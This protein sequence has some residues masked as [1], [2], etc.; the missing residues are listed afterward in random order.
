MAIDS[1]HAPMEV[2]SRARAWFMTMAFVA[3]RKPAW[4]DFQTAIFASD[5][6]ME[7]VLQTSNG[8]SPPVTH[9]VTAWAATAN[10][11][12][13]Q[14]RIS[15]KPLVQFVTN[16][17]AWVHRWSWAAPAGSSGHPRA[18]MDLPPAVAADV[19]HLRAQAR[20]W[21]SMAARQRADTNRANKGQGRD[22]NG[23]KGKGKDHSKQGVGKGKDRAWQRDN[24][25]RDDRRD[26]SRRR[27]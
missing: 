15:G 8:I 25:D 2:Y 13:E 9:F 5:K 18:L 7:L 11:F 12:S 24:D 26:R 1:V 4:F 27:R 14:V 17:G 16:T 22:G 6:I 23:G 20:Q 3:I 21:Q 10:H 19:E